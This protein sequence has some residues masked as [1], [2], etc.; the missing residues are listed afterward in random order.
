[1]PTSA[2]IKWGF[3]LVLLYS[4]Y[5]AVYHF[6]ELQK[7]M[8]GLSNMRA[9]LVPIVAR[10]ID[11]PLVLGMVVVALLF[12]RHRALRALIFENKQQWLWM[13]LGAAIFVVAV[14]LTTPKTTVDAYWLMHKLVTVAFM[15]ELCYRVLLFSWMDEAGLGN[16][17]YLLSGAFWGG[18]STIQTIVVEDGMGIVAIIVAALVGILVGTLMAVVY[19][20]TNSLWFITYLQ[21]T[22]ALLF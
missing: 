17:A 14:F 2:W 12:D 22:L 6:A 7:L 3:Y 8:M 1:M 18:M 15:G 19:K 20:K 5:T 10:H 4:L 11:L 9:S 13:L 16:L 21:A